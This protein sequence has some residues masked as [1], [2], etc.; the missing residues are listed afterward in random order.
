MKNFPMI[1]EYMATDLITLSPN[2]EITHAMMTLLNA[3]ISGAPVVG[4]TGLLVGV[5]SKKDCL[6][7]AL[8]ASY[9]QEWGGAVADYM[10]M[11]IETL[12][13]DLDVIQAAEAFLASPYRRFPV[14]D[15]GNLIGQVSRSDILKALSE[16]WTSTGGRTG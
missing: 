15:E 3:R 7:A 2:T 4:E 16:L 11:K 9:Y 10:S 14:L 13:G 6:K 8:S 5:L 1:R 12:D